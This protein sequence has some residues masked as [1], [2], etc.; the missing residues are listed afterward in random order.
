MN[1]MVMPPLAKSS[2]H[3]C[4][5]HQAPENGSATKP[6]HA[7]VEEQVDTAQAFTNNNWQTVVGILTVGR[8]PHIHE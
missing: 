4:T 7:A 1:M 2:L 8:K 5:A 3:V 6:S